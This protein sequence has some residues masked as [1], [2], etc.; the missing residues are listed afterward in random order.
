MT[1]VAT[2]KH[3]PL[4]YSWPIRN[5]IARPHGLVTITH[6]KSSNYVYHKVCM[7]YMYGLKLASLVDTRLEG[8]LGKVMT[9]CGRNCPKGQV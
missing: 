9:S 4:H 6:G 1:H 8:N 5:C 2:A 7:L 3:K